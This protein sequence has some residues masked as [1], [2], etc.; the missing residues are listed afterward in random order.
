MERSDR[1]FSENSGPALLFDDPTF[2]WDGP[3][4][5]SQALGPGGVMCI[6]SFLI[7]VS[8]WGFHYQYHQS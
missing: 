1:S 4:V 8:F 5:M 2:M 6:V 7:F 3:S